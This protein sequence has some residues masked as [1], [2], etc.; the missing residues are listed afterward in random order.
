MVKAVLITTRQDRH[1]LLLITSRQLHPK[2]EH[3]REHPDKCRRS[4]PSLLRTSRGAWCHHDSS[5]ARLPRALRT[6]SRCLPL[7]PSPTPTRDDNDRAYR[8]ALSTR[9]RAEIERFSAPSSTRAGELFLARI[10]EL[11]PTPPRGAPPPG[12]A[13]R[14]LSTAKT[15]KTEM[16]PNAHDARGGGAIRPVNG[17]ECCG[18]RSCLTAGSAASVWRLV[19]LWRSLRDLRVF[20]VRKGRATAGAGAARSR[21]RSG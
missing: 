15:R 17:P 16:P 12:P 18:Q 5:T 21:R 9:S 2:G 11:R 7:V 6:S 10:D 3:F 19:A 20:A 1:P 13:V 8:R 4:A 14:H